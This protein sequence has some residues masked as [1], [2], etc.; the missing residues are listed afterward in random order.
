MQVSTTPNWTYP[1]GAP[2]LDLGHPQFGGD[3]WPGTLVSGSFVPDAPV[4]VKLWEAGDNLPAVLVAGLTESFA[5][6]KGGVMVPEPDALFGPISTGT[7]VIF[8]LHGRWPGGL[9]VGSAITLQWWIADPTAPQ[10]MS[11]ST[12]VRIT[13]P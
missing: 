9:P 2:Q 10:G 8:E 13:Q 11:A 6:F 1:A 3:G 5:P 12:A 7:N 4:T